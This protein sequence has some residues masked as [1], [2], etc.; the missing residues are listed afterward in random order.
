[1]LEVSNLA[2]SRGD[3]RLFSGL[4]FTLH[5]GE[6]LQIQ[7]ANGSGKTSLLRTLCGF[8]MQDEGTISWFGSEVQGIREEYYAEVMYLGHLNAIKDELSALENLRISAGLSGA[9][10]TDQEAIAALRRMG[11][12]GRETLPTKVL[13][14]GQRRRVALARMLVSEA[15]LWILDE[16]LTALDVGA[17]CLIQ[18][19]LAEHLAQQGMVIFTTH[20][21]LEVAGMEMRSLSL[22]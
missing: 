20:Q 2:C 22:S 12:K 11:L 4:S 14:Q 5:P 6:I 16:P 21:P 9:V 18:E 7:G 15:K 3:H 8:L 17:V 10:L 19:L 1:M 13:S